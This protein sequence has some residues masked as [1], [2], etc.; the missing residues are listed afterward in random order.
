MS[1]A[2][3]TV[4][5]PLETALIGQVLDA[6]WTIRALREEVS[7][8]P[9]R[10]P[11]L[12][13]LG[14]N[15]QDERA[16]IRAL[17]LRLD[18]AAPD[19]LKDLEMRL[20]VFNY[21]RE[22]IERLAGERLRGIVR[23]L[24]S[25]SIPFAAAPLGRIYYLIVEW[26]DDDLRSQVALHD[27]F[28]ASYALRVLHQAAIALH[29][30]HQRNVAHQ[31][32]R[33][34][35]VVFFG[36]Q[37]KLGEFSCAVDGRKPRPDGTPLL[38]WTSAPPESLYQAPIDSMNGRC[39]I[40][41]Y[42]LGS[43]VAYLFSGTSLTTQL[44]QRLQPIHHWRH[45]TGSFAEALPYVNHAFGDALREMAAHLPEPC[46]DEFLAAMREL[47][48]PDPAHRGHPHN[49]AGHGP[50]YSTE[51]YISLFDRLATRLEQGL[52]RRL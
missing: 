28:D 33:P 4:P 8:G 38:D 37:V 26:S 40:D 39:L 43:L 50:Q 11:T 9:I 45:W 13:F 46:R 15:G 29:E 32:V 36:S 34:A 10:I 21:Q 41:L 2:N 1:T 42:Q 48:A 6:G 47:C 25:G 30:L 24:H 22:L 51:R 3:P 27:E 12:S 7:S 17:D 49:R 52:P 23:G 44:A 35:N 16:L 5:V 31:S 20:K 14:T 18:P 19:E